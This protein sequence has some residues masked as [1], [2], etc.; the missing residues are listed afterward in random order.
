MH[1]GAALQHVAVLRVLEN[2]GPDVLVAGLVLADSLRQCDLGE[3][4]EKER[5]RGEQ[6]GEKGLKGT[7]ERE[8]ILKGGGEKRDDRRR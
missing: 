3:G 7:R 2:G 6:G 8:E 4:G 1:V 5:R